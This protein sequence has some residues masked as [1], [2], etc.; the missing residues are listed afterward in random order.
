MSCH[1]AS[2]VFRASEYLDETYMYDTQIF[3]SITS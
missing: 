1:V 2:V 3:V